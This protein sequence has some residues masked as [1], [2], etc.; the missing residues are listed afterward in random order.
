MLCLSETR[1]G[2]RLAVV[3]RVRMRMVLPWLKSGETVAESLAA[4]IQSHHGR[5]LIL[6]GNGSKGN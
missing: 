6:L 3:I 4:V 1:P 2:G 5:D